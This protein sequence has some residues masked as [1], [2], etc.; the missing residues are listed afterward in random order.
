MLGVFPVLFFFPY[1]LCIIIDDFYNTY[2]I[3]GKGIATCIIGHSGIAMECRMN[4]DQ[5][6]H[7]HKCLLEKMTPLSVEERI[8]K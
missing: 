6:E 1:W 2:D 4:L 8:E 5:R 3:A 7:V